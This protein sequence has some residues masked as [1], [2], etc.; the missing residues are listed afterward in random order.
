MSNPMSFIR[1][2]TSS[3]VPSFQ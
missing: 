3:K 1:N 2:R